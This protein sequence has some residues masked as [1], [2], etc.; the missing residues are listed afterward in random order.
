[1]QKEP[2]ICCMSQKYAKEQIKVE[3]LCFKKWLMT[4]IFLPLPDKR[5]PA[6]TMALL[7]VIASFLCCINIGRCRLLTLLSAFK[8]RARS[9]GLK[10][11]EIT[12]LS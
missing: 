6:I 11:K 7:Y 2:K 9:T 5:S 10:L 3:I 12:S 8:C 4:T 1:M